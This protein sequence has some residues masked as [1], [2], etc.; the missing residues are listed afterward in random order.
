MFNLSFLSQLSDL[1]WADSNST[2]SSAIQVIIG[3]DLYG[4]ILKDGIKRGQPGQPVAQNSALGWIISGPIPADQSQPD[5]SVHLTVHH[6]KSL[7]PLTQEI[8]RFWELKEIPLSQI[9][10]PSEEACEE[11]FCSTHSRDSSSRYIVRLPFKSE[12]PINLGYSQHSAGRQFQSLYRRL[13][14]NH[15]LKSEYEAFMREYEA[16]GHMRQAPDSRDPSRQ[17]VYIPHH[18]VLRA[19][20][21]TTRLRV[22]F[23]ASYASSNG[24]SLNDHLLV[25][26]K[27]QSDLFAIILKWR[28]FRYVYTADI[29]KMYRQILVDSRDIDFQR[30]MWQPESCDKPQE[31]QLLT[32]TYGMACAPF[33][34]L[35]VLKQLIEDDGCKF[36]LAVPVLS[37]QIYVD[38]VLFG[39]NDAHTLGQIRDQVTSLLQCGQFTL[40]K[41]A[42]NLSE[43][44]EDI[45]PADHG[46]ACDKS[47]LP[48]DNLKI[49]GIVWNPA[50]DSFQFKVKL[51]Q[52]SPRSKRSILSTI[53]KLYDPLG[54]V[55]PVISAAKIFMQSLW[56]A[57]LGWDD[58]IPSPLL[59][60]W[61]SI[62]DSLTYLNDVTIP[63]WTQARPDSQVL[64]HGFA[65]AST[66]AYAAAIYLKITSKSGDVTVSLLAG[67]SRVTPLNSLTV[68]RFEL[69]A[70]HLLARLLNYV[71]TSLQLDH[72]GCHCWSDS[73]IVLAWI[74]SHGTRWNTFVSNRVN[75]I[76]SYLPDARWRHV[77]TSDNPA[78]SASRGLLGKEI[79]FHHLWWH[80][81][82]WL[83]LDSAEWPQESS[84]HPDD[85]VIEE[86]PC[87]HHVS[88]PSAT[89]DLATKYSSWVKLIRVT[90]YVQKFIN[91]CRRS[92]RDSDQSNGRQLTAEHYSKAKT[93]WIKQTQVALF[94]S[95]LKTIAA[96]Q[97]L[98]SKS[99]LLPLNPYL[100]SEGVLR[101]D[102][103]LHNAPLPYNMGH[104]IILGQHP[105]VRLIVLQLHIRSLHGGQQLTLSRLRQNFWIIRA[106]NLVKSVIHNC[107]VCVREKAAVPTQLMGNLPAARVTPSPRS[108]SHC[109]L[110][111]A[112]PVKVRSSAG[113]GIASHKAYIALFVC[114]ASRAIHLELVS[115]YS[116]EAFISAFH[117]FCSRRGIPS[118]VYSDNGTTFVGADKELTSAYQAAVRN[119]KLQGL[120]ATDNIKWHF[121][122]PSA[123]HFGGLWEA[124]IRSVKHHIRRVLGDRTFSYE[125]FNTLLCQI[126]ACLNSRPLAPLSNFPDDY[127]FLTPGHFLIGT[128]ITCP[129]EPSLLTV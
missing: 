123:P 106:R 14:S 126:E 77:P 21:A 8:K 41:W 58:L 31:Y 66:H 38:D 121:I 44:L 2:S 86:K 91:A 56:Q 62:Y 113:R 34:A 15:E 46:L 127:S 69:L 55:T 119:P 75:Q 23:N 37:N 85:C 13:Q 28:Q 30:I 65:D 102:R 52:P 98:S 92:N 124:G 49:L 50:G 35:R 19:S 71:R 72:V 57:Q 53:A 40:R 48:D 67:K 104:L 78:D 10:T 32:V 33:L 108:F 47:L 26:Q 84:G 18:P 1:A 54:W 118:D 87:A 82:H 43:L 60:K 20:S 79:S 128:A 80:G 68:P 70:A 96:G 103:R 115:S 107:I 73:I 99:V 76:Q 90:A 100:D 64:L 83:K 7:Q 93:F 61:L 6:C 97:A 59:I 117:R 74:R 25:G 3:A 27:L 112:G 114:L 4:E 109:G 120:T 110:D 95:E 116:T 16:L 9:L 5:H 29:A 88:L 11:H 81:P 45:E 129:P 22:V 36:P 51:E 89:W 125:E 63:R 12:T 105:L 42:S 17:R 111:Y 101:V 94:G 24:T 122:P 39:D